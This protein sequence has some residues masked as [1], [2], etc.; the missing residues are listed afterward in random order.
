[1]FIS[2]RIIPLD[3]S[4]SMVDDHFAIYIAD[5]ITSTLHGFAFGI[6]A[7]T[8]PVLPSFFYFPSARAMGYDMH[9]LYHRFNLAT[10]DVPRFR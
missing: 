1:M 3:L 5:N 8:Y 9:G 6:K 7:A 10:G 2:V 4:I